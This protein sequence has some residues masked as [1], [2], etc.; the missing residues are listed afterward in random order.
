MQE[1]KILGLDIGTTSIGW[2]VVIERAIEKLNSMIIAAGVRRYPLSP[3]ETKE[4]ANGE[5]ISTNV[6]RRTK[7]SIRRNN[8]RFKLRREDL[9]EL[10]TYNGIISSDTILSEEGKDTTF[11]TLRLRAKAATEEISLEDFS[12]VLL[13]LNK[14]R[15]YRSNRKTDREEDGDTGVDSLDVA[16][17]LHHKGMTPGEYAY[18]LITLGKFN[19][20]QFYKSDLSKELE[21]IIATQKAYHPSLPDNLT[22]LIAGKNESKTWSILAGL[23]NLKGIKRHTKRGRDSKAEE[24]KWRANALHTPLDAEQLAEV[25]SK[26][27]KEVSSASGL[28]SAMSDRS[29]ELVINGETIGQYKMRKLTEN[30]HFSFK[31]ISFYRKDYEAEFDRIW[32]TQAKFH[33]ELTPD[34]KNEIR[35]RVIFY[36]RPLKSQKG[37]VAYCELESHVKEIT[38]EGNTK[39]RTIGPKVAPKSSPLFQQFR[40]WQELN[41]LRIN[42]APLTLTQKQLLADNLEFCRKM[43]DREIIMMLG[44]IPKNVRLNVKEIDGNHTSTAILEA[45]ERML[46]FNGFDDTTLVGMSPKLRAT[47]V[48]RRLEEMGISASILYFDSSLSDKDFEGQPAYRLWHVIY[49]AEA[50][51]SRSGTEKLRKTLA[52]ILSIDEDLVNPFCHIAFPDGYGSLS[53]KAIRKILPFMKQGMMYSD[54]CEAAGLNHSKRSQPKEQ[55][56]SRTYA[57]H[58]DVL[59]KNSLRSPVV[60]KMLNQMIHVVNQ[61]IAI[62]GPFDEIRVEM[63]RELKKNAKQR[64]EM[65]TAIKDREKDNI[66]IAEIIKAAPFNISRPGK[67]DILRYRLYEELESNGFKTLYSNTYIPKEEL[68]GKRFN[69]EHILPKS[70]LFDDSYA[71]KTLETV[72]IN[73]EKN[74]LTAYDFV[75]AKYGENAAETYKNRVTDLEKKGKISRTKAKHLRMAAADIPDDFLNRDLSLTQYINRKALELLEEVC[76]TITSTTGAVTDRL[77][78]DWGL[79]DVMKELNWEKYDRQGLTESYTN[80]DG[81]T[82]RKIVDWTKRNDNRH[83]A[84]DAITIA[85]TRPEYVNYLSN[86]NAQND[87]SGII[88]SI[89]KRYLERDSSGNLRFLPPMPAGTMRMEVKRALEAILVST[90]A[91]NKVVTTNIVTTKSKNEAPPKK[92]PTPRVQLHNDTFYGRSYEY[93]T[94]MVK[95]G[96]SMDAGT[97]EQVASK[98]HREALARRLAEFG[99]NPKKAFTGKNSLAKNPVFVDPAHTQTVPDTVKICRL[100]PYF[101]QRVSI[102]EKIDISRVIDRRVRQILQDRLDRFNGNAKKAFSNL[103]EDPIYLN[104]AKG[105]A[106]KKVTVKPRVSSPVALHEAHDHNGKVLKAANGSFIPSDFVVTSG[107]HHAALFLTPEGK[108]E[109]VV[110]SYF[111]AVTRAIQSAPVIDRNYRSEDGW[112]FLMTIKKN[113]YFVFP[114][115]EK[116]ADGKTS[117]MTFNPKDIDLLDPENYPIVSKHLY[118]VQKFSQRYYMFRHHLE[119]T[120][121]ETRELLGTTWKRIRTTEQ[122]IDAIKVRV[123]SIGRIVAVG[124]Y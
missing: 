123:D 87:K 3:D 36:Q 73:L 31:N 121:E 102:S 91:K 68:F 99:G 8:Q 100:E 48:A 82:V 51:D 43:T 9:I 106:I 67:N 41:N 66:R 35:E 47:T 79:V 15:G 22:E 55:L 110:V 38:I 119:T 6:G 70:V 17:E 42:D 76:P 86:L 90:K 75:V 39:K 26:I 65:T 124:E 52:R 120:V 72:D 78:Q 92:Y 54:A 37:K 122:M 112:K 50:D 69:I 33:P 4:F 109:E 29:K 80:R 1:K 53:A 46:T 115:Y 103:D 30:P 113:E 27:N 107:N 44:L 2:A 12:K 94:S 114:E 74:N 77:R 88:Y 93:V 5:T 81:K 11:S 49:S 85:F 25:V 16:V 118:R 24:L 32:D 104:E 34:L 20:P 60:E 7:L 10:L 96:V 58:I 59:A 18:Q 63:A 40:I 116:S 64:E 97:I 89:R 56:D 111:E 101:T 108:V 62:Y 45:C 105:I 23:L 84:M 21:R 71:N 83:H 57:D 95:V 28:L 19:L 117:V 14:K 61:L 13:M 98:A